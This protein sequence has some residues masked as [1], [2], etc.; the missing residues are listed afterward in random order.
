[1]TDTEGKGLAGVRIHS[2][3]TELGE[4][5]GD[6][7]F[8]IN[9]LA[10]GL[11][12]PVSFER[13]GYIP[14]TEQMTGGSTTPV[15][16]TLRRG[17]TL[18]G[19]VRDGVG[20]PAAG[21][22]VTVRA[23]DGESQT[24]T[25]ETQADGAF[26]FDG[27]SSGR[28][29]LLAYRGDHAPVKTPPYAIDEGETQSEIVLRLSKGVEVRVT[30][31][32]PDGSPA[33]CRLFVYGPLDRPESE[34][35][36]SRGS[37]QNEEPPLFRVMPGAYRIVATPIRPD[38][39]AG[40]SETELEISASTEFR[41][42]LAEKALRIRVTG[43]FPAGAQLT[44]LQ[45]R[46]T[47]PAEPAFDFWAQRDPDGN[48]ATPGLPPGKYRLSIYWRESDN[49]RTWNTKVIEGVEPSEQALKVE[50]SK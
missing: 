37:Y 47:E 16:V 1:V 49:E 25:Q 18:M 14:V 31:V 21:A 7:S 11:P 46:R 44:A 9:G 36:L 5:K 43:N 4:T 35:I 3:N 45:V 26:R 30:P 33:D 22:N 41:I 28:Y 13:D 34:R 38:E 32:R 50:L 6:G 15:R 24:V 23:V 48:L 10:D 17:G 12:V 2:G 19:V 27:L 29:V 39:T 20:S 40:A 42:P 8:A